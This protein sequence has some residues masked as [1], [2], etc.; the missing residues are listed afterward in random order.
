MQVEN[1]ELPVQ[2]PA[3]GKK[4]L[5]GH[6]VKNTVFGEFK[7]RIAV[8]TNSKTNSILFYDLT[9]VAEAK[10]KVFPERHVNL[11]DAVIGKPV[12]QEFTLL[13]RQI[14]LADQLGKLNTECRTAAEVSFNTIDKNR[15]SAKVI[16]TPDG[17]EKYAFCRVIIP[18]LSE[19]ECSPLV[20]SVAALV[21][22]R[23][24]VSP[25][26]IEINRTA[27]DSLQDS[28]E[29]TV[30]T[31][32]GSPEFSIEDVAF[33]FPGISAKPAVSTG[34]NYSLSITL[35]KEALSHLEEKEKI[36]LKLSAENIAP[37]FVQLSLK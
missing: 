16:F 1:D 13:S 33:T 14:N 27:E 2:V 23:L 25:E 19:E 30:N 5:K 26:K 28:F 20:L 9:G 37:A 32:D 8:Q 12:I 3:G 22:P 10:I 18:V 35:P 15:T 6:A 36:H 31:T 21:S 34:Q 7:K 11:K 4:I 17:K 29:L 24:L